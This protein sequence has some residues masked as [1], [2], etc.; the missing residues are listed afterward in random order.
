[1]CPPSAKVADLT[2][3]ASLTRPTFHVSPAL[4][5]LPTLAHSRRQNRFT[6]YQIFRPRHFNI[7][8]APF[9]DRH[10]MPQPFHQ[11][12]VIRGP[13]PFGMRI[14]VSGLNPVPSKGLRSLREP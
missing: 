8:A 5:A 12:C 1:M 9:N 2:R 14:P 11:E 13:H 10:R 4:L 6:D 7:L 3:W